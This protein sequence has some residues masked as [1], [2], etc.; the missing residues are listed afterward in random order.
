[1][2]TQ[3]SNI[4]AN[5][6]NDVYQKPLNPT[7]MRVP[8]WVSRGRYIQDS[9]LPVQR[10]YYLRQSSPSYLRVIWAMLRL[11]ELALKANNDET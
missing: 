7:L 11:A 8:V 10:G 3:I 5:A 4:N 9:T 1:M 2:K 6:T